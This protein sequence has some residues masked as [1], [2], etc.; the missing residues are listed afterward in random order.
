MLHQPFD[1][2]PTP[3]AR[4]NVLFAYG[5]RPFFLLAGIFSPLLL[6]AW[7]AIFAG[8]L[9]APRWLV[10]LWWHGHEMVFGFVAAVVAGFLLTAVPN[11]TNT[12]RTH[13][14][15][16][17]LLVMLWLAGRVAMLLVNFLPP[18]VVAAIDLAFFPALAATL[19]PRIYTAKR[20]HNYGFP[21]ILLGFFA[22]NLLMHLNANEVSFPG[23]QV[24]HA[25]FGLRL[26]VYLVILLIVILGGRVIPNFTTNGLLR[27]GK[28]VKAY[29]LPGTEEFATPLFLLFVVL[30]LFFSRSIFAG[31]A[32]AA[33]AVV[34]FARMAGWQTRHTLS[35][36]LIWSLHLGFVWIPI[37]LVMLA[38]SY[39][40]GILPPNSGLHALTAGCV[41]TITL[42]MMSR[43][44]LGHTGRMLIA[45]RAMTY[46]YLLASS[47]GL[48]RSVGIALFPD[49]KASLHVLV[50]AGAL[51]IAAF[52]VFF[53]TYYPILTRPRLDGK[54]G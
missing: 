44:A 51:W 9:P 15:P 46:A 12:V 48:V 25:G 53:A 49:P 10:P 19:A 37:G 17:V 47:A 52:L 29:N 42:A 3:P 40:F 26:S 32:A 33:C 50:C 1:P 5:F 20:I 7:L 18:F 36:P 22:G 43:V 31:V 30:D 41:G 13:G 8:V 45:P 14:L 11:W 16:L 6:L 38:A 23:S 21:V 28:H 34:L 27:S 4:Q 35:D 2:K 54:P 24:L 39:V